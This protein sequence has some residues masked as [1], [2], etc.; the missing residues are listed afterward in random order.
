MLNPFVCKHI[1]GWY[2]YS[3]GVSVGELVVCSSDK[4]E[5]NKPAKQSTQSEI[6][7]CCLHGQEIE[8]D[9]ARS[10]WFVL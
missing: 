7:R 10:V 4:V 9:G 6:L 2:G 3:N 8:A 5:D 1:T